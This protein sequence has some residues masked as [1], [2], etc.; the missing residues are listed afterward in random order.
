MKRHTEP[1]NTIFSKYIYER[2]EYKELN[3]RTKYFVRRT[4]LSFSYVCI[5]LYA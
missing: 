1:R 5:E 4:R 3:V 2:N